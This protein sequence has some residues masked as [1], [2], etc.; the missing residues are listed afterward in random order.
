MA[1]GPYIPA[2][3]DG[4]GAADG[5]PITNPG[6]YSNNG[7]EGTITQTDTD[8]TIL[9]GVS[10]YGNN[11]DAWTPRAIAADLARINGTDN[12][13]DQHKKIND[14]CVVV[15]RVQYL[16]SKSLTLGEYNQIVRWAHRYTDECGAGILELLIDVNDE[17]IYDSG[18]FP[19]L[20]PPD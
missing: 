6:G 8:F 17:I 5:N 10:Y 13:W 2:L 11:I 15:A 3:L 1:F 7:F 18:G 16:V 4:S 9:D 14:V 19:I 20:V 12:L